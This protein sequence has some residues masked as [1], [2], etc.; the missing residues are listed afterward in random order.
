M[1]DFFFSLFI[2][3]YYL[4]FEKKIV[5]YHGGTDC[6]KNAQLRPDL[7]VAEMQA[8]HGFFVF[9]FINNGIKGVIQKKKVRNELGICHLVSYV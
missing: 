8:S 6:S 3:Y 5:N 9:I 2:N 4:Q 1:Y 7:V